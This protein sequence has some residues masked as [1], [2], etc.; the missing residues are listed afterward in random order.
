MGF[1]SSPFC[2]HLYTVHG[3]HK[4][5]GNRNLIEGHIKLAPPTSFTLP[6][7]ARQTAGSIGI[8]S[9]A[10]YR[11][12][13][14]LSRFTELC[15]GFSQQRAMIAFRNLT[16]DTSGFS[17]PFF[18][19]NMEEP[20]EPHSGHSLYANRMCVQRETHMLTDPASSD[21]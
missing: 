14:L 15:S 7:L 13:K 18:L 21:V 17:T 2:K 20:E 11:I 5:R 4:V 8:C 6:I 3:R 12:A 16:P 10:P 9:L 1:V 19:R